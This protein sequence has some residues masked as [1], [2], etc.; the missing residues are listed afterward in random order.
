MQHF[1][2]RTQPSIAELEKNLGVVLFERNNKQV[3][4]TSIGK[5]LLE[6]AR[7]IYLDAQ[8]LVERAHAEQ[9]HLSFSMNIGFIPTIAPYLLPQSPPHPARTTPQLQT[10]YPRTTHRNPTQQPLYWTNRRRRHRP[11]LSPAKP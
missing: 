3:L 8:Q 1:P 2:I 10:S 11:T 9:N 5:E 6:R 7:Q 4:V